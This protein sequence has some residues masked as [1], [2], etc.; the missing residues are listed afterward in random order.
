MKSSFFKTVLAVICGVLILR[1]LG[2]L[3]F[4]LFL[5]GAVAGGG[6]SIPRS[7]V[8]DLDMSTFVI[9]EQSKESTTP[10]VMSMNFDMTPVVGLHDAVTAIGIAATDPGVKYILL[11]ADNMSAGMADVEELRNALANFRTSGKAVVAYTDNPGNGSYYLATVADKIYMGSQHG[12]N[13]MLIGLS[14][15]LMFFKDILDKLGVKVQLIRHGKYKSAR[16]D[17]H[18][19]HRLGR[20]P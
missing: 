5:G 7:G 15:R 8:L 20:K 11:R 2:L 12:G 10:D 17:V 14:A 19:Q 3:L 13:S 4:F 16:G 6:A 9:Q 1:V 18:P